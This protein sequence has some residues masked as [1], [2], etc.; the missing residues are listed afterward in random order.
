MMRGGGSC[1]SPLAGIHFY[2]FYLPSTYFAVE[3]F[4]ACALQL[5]GTEVLGLSLPAAGHAD[6]AITKTSQSY[7]QS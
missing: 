6:A 1:L 3:G 4:R 5:P 2:T 7:S